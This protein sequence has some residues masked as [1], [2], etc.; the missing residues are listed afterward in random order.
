MA[1]QYWSGVGK[2]AFSIGKRIL[3]EAAPVAVDF[4]VVKAVEKACRIIEAKLH[5]LYVSTAI[6]SGIT[7]ILNLA[8]VLFIYFKPFGDSVSRCCA[9]GCFAIAFLFWLFRTIRAIRRY[10]KIS[11]AIFKSALK[12]KSIYNGIEKYVLK[13]FRLISLAYAGVRIGSIF[14][15]YLQR[16]PKV[17]EF[18]EYIVL[19]FWKRVALYC[20]IVTIYSISIYWVL[21]PI[22]LDMLNFKYF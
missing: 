20:G 6:N 15:P 2:R 4:L 11:I 10:G 13:N 16:I 9:I 19:M 1:S 17:S 7:F 18:V 22:L 5:N 14:L 21:K 8:G 12:E 3:K